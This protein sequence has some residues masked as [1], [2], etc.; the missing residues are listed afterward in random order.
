MLTAFFFTNT[1]LHDNMVNRIFNKIYNKLKLPLWHHDNIEC[2]TD[3]DCPIPYACCHDP[4]FPMKNN[5]C[6]INYKEREYKYKYAQA[7]T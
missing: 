5:Y 4:F 3:N 2:Q 1:N 6:C 7:H